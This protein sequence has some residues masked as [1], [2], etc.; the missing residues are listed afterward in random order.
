MSTPEEETGE[1]IKHNFH[2]SPPSRFLLRKFIVTVTPY[3]YSRLTRTT[4]SR[5]SELLQGARYEL[6]LSLAQ[7]ITPFLSDLST[8]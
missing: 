1:D 7:E 6:F 2:M 5:K 4:V 8:F 3:A